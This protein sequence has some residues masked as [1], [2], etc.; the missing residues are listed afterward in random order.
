MA[1]V[2]AIVQ[3]LQREPAWPSNLALFY[4]SEERLAHFRFALDRLAELGKEHGFVP[5]VLL[6]PVLT[7]KHHALWSAAYDVV[8]HIANSY[9]I[10]VIQVEEAFRHVGL[11]KLRQRPRDRIHPNA[12]GHR[13]M[14]EHLTEYFIESNT[15]GPW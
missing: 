7:K 1:R 14:A 12:K 13:I 6:V 3:A 8:E 4:R 15:L 5:V 11:A 9:F 10:D 2:E